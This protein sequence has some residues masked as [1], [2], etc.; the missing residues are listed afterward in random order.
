[1]IGLQI[2]TIMLRWRNHFCQL[3][4]AHGVHDVRQTEIHTAEPLLNEASAF[5]I[6][7][8]IEEIKRHKSSTDKIPAELIKAG[9]RTINYES[10]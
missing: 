1:M 3:L 4:N 6:D 9:C 10:H 5:E 7:M 2:T 8:V